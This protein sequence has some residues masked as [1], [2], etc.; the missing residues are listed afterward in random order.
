[1]NNV[2]SAIHIIGH[3]LLLLF[4]I[5]IWL[6]TGDVSITCIA[7][8]ALNIAWKLIALLEP[9]FG[10]IGSAIIIGGLCYLAC[11]NGGI[12]DDLGTCHAITTFIRND[13]CAKKI[14][15][16]Y[17]RTSDLTG[18]KNDFD[19]AKDF[20]YFARKKWIDN[21]IVSF[22]EDEWQ[23]ELDTFKDWFKNHK[24]PQDGKPP[25]PG[26]NHYTE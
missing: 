22:K 25:I 19:I 14:F 5:C 2:K 12:I 6:S 9:Q 17:Y 23:K 1:M 7:Y 24:Y 10:E 26:I 13:E 8:I 16:E 15:P 20:E 21:N 4:T 18:N 11:F 3:I